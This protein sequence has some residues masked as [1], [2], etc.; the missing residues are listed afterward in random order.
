MTSARSRTQARTVSSVS[1]LYLFCFI[2]SVVVSWA[3]ASQFLLSGQPS[4]SKFFELA[5]A[6]SVAT[7]VSSDILLSA[8]IFLFF[9]YRELKRLGMPLNR[10]ALYILLTG[11]VGICASLS[12]FLYQREN[13]LIK[14]QT[15]HQTTT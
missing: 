7:L 12:M 2:I 3:I 10:M 13:W 1:T 8:S 4:L 14:S 11:S 5:F 6:N 9:A 15:R